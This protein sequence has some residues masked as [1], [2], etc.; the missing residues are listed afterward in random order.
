MPSRPGNEPARRAAQGARRGLGT[1]GHA[2]AGAAALQR[3]PAV[4]AVDDHA[5]AGARKALNLSVYTLYE[6]AADLDW[7]RVTT[8]RWI[9]E[10]AR[11]NNR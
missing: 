8:A 6:N 4:R 3:G 2:H 7:V 1:A 5:D 9:D 11:L 10:I